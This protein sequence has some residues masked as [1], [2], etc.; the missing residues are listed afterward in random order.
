[1]SVLVHARV[2]H[3]LS[4]SGYHL[5]TIVCVYTWPQAGFGLLQPLRS[6]GQYHRSGINAQNAAT[7]HLIHACL[8]QHGGV[9]QLDRNWKSQP[10]IK[11][12]ALMQE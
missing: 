11:A 1:M 7:F 2:G 5:S 10:V 12:S 4:C 8:L 3:Q 6:F 9:L